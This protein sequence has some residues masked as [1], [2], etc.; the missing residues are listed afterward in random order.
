MATIDRRLSWEDLPQMLTLSECAALCR[1]SPTSTYEACRR[2]DGWLHDIATK[3]GSQWRIPRDRL[4]AP[5][6]AGDR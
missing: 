5:L 3:C 1:V 2:S 4:R 6:E